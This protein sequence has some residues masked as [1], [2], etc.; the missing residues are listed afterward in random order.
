MEYVV[1]WKTKVSTVQIVTLS[2][3]EALETA[4]FVIRQHGAICH[5]TDTSGRT[6]SEEDLRA[7]CAKEGP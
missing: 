7:A 3:C 4:S 2:A 1:H 5:V 6:V